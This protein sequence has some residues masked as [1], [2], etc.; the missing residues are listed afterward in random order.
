MN[1]KEKVIKLIK[2]KIS[3]CNEKR[4]KSE[5]ITESNVLLIIIEIYE[6]LI[7]D[8]NQTL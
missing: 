5:S 1:E 2:S 8:I 6:N 3:E 4:N 7:N